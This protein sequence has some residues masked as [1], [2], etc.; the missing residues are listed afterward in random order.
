MSAAEEL[1]SLFIRPTRILYVEDDEM[2]GQVFIESLERDF[3]CSIV[4][5]KTG[6]DAIQAF[7]RREFD[8]VFLDLVLPD[9][10]GIQVLQAIRAQ[11]PGLP[12]VITTGQ[13]DTD[14]IMQAA[15]EGVVCFMFKPFHTNFS[16]RTVFSTFKVRA[17][18]KEDAAYFES[19]RRVSEP[20][21][22]SA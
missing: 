22:V 4:W 16:F 1:L 3:E 12:V 18:T 20:E 17:R 11:S 15:E 13:A 5:A 9:I 10:T 7:E 2:L 6:R 8:I 14:L 21:L 19:R